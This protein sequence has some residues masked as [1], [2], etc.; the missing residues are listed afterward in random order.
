MSQTKV[1]QFKYQLQ[2]RTQTM[3]HRTGTPISQFP[4]PELTPHTCYLTKFDSTSNPMDGNNKIL[5][6]N[7]TYK[8]A[9][10]K[11]ED[12]NVLGVIYIYQN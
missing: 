2:Y 12:K 4:A 6:S 11:K 1:E 7:G 10:S 3:S 8:V 5:N 9:V